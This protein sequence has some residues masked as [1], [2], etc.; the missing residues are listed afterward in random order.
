MKKN[1]Y[2]LGFVL[3]ISSF[4]TITSFA[5]DSLCTEN[6]DTEQYPIGDVLTALDLIKN[7]MRAS[8]CGGPYLLEARYEIDGSDYGIAD[9]CFWKAPVTN[10]VPDINLAVLLT[11]NVFRKKI[12]F[13][14]KDNAYEFI[15][16]KGI[17]T[18][19]GDPSLI[20]ICETRFPQKMKLQAQIV[21]VYGKNNCVAYELNINNTLDLLL[22]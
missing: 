13:S 7:Q 12:F 17:L 19:R 15:D 22:Y 11:R 5:D 10:N 1:I 6:Q 14:Q 20:T 9:K 21:T 4:Y 16:K 8:K 2:I 3:L 18:Q